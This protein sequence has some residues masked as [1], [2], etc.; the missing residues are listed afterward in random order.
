M[1]GCKG[2]SVRLGWFLV[3]YMLAP[4]PGYLYACTCG[5]VIRI[6][7]PFLKSENQNGEA[8]PVAYFRFFFAWR[9]LHLFTNPI[10]IPIQF[11]I[12]ILLPHPPLKKQ[13]PFKYCGVVIL[14]KMKNFCRFFRPFVNRE[15]AQKIGFVFGTIEALVLEMML[16]KTFQLNGI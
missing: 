10:S 1:G 9:P 12:F 5:V 8:T 13:A 3:N 2:A 7:V 4:G 14:K 6:T 11:R 16:K 15:F